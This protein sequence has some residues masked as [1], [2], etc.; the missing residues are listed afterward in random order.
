MMSM[1]L[2]A[3]APCFGAASTAD[4]QAQRRRDQEMAVGVSVVPD[5]MDPRAGWNNIHF[6]MFNLFTRTLVHLDVAGSVR[7]DLA[8][9]WSIS[10]DGRV[11]TFKLSKDARFDDGAPVRSEDVAYSLSRHFWPGSPS[12]IREF[13][14]DILAGK[15]PTAQ[16]EY[17][18]AISTPD[19]STLV[20]RLPH[21]Y[22]PFLELLCMPG[23]GIIKRGSGE[24]PDP[25]GTGAMRAKFRKAEREWVFRPADGTSGMRLISI[26]QFPHDAAILKAL[27]EGSVDLALGFTLGGIPDDALP[28]SYARVR[29]A[30]SP[31]TLHLYVND[32]AE[33]MKSAELRRAL[34]DLIQTTFSKFPNPGHYLEPQSTF[35]PRGFLPPAY[36]R[37]PSRKLSADEFRTRWG[38]ETAGKRLDVILREEYLSSV[39]ADE[40]RGVLRQAGFDARVI[41]K[42]IG[43]VH[44]DFKSGEYDAAMGGYFAS[45]ADADGFLPPL[46]P[47]N[48]LRFGSFPAENFFAQ[49]AGARFIKTTE[50]RRAR[51]LDIMSRF[52]DEAYVIPLFGLHFPL[53][54]SDALTLP[55]TTFR[56]N[57]NL[58]KISWKAQ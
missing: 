41:Q 37:R 55:D 18:P 10:P 57:L 36:Y 27:R 43:A 33:F 21:P 14:Q 20:I 13:L 9:S 44:A 4:S 1:L 54:A 25:I 32:R 42:K 12:I 49:V 51:Y 46:S 38:K 50:E 53:L 8:S 23:F 28:K 11:Y 26:K 24:T 40:L 16:G 39:I 34:R 30:Y 3:A 5:S 17:L 58:S 56:Y 29:R 6:L 45:I 22:P 2:A 47:T 19:P 15:K 31:G 52:E 7:S 48:N 35:L